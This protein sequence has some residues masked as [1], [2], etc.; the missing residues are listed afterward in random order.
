MNGAA[1]TSALTHESAP[2]PPDGISPMA[3]LHFATT[4]K[5]Y[6]PHRERPLKGRTSSSLAQW[7]AVEG[8]SGQRERISVCAYGTSARYLVSPKGALPA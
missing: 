4:S 5:M 2:Q 6:A 7:T 3:A 8:N 1:R